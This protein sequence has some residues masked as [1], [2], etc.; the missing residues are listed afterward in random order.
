MAKGIGGRAPLS[1]ELPIW[2]GNVS[3]SGEEALLPGAETLRQAGV[4]SE[5]RGPVRLGS[6]GQ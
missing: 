1:G 5:R 2:W 6:I 4:S 3:T